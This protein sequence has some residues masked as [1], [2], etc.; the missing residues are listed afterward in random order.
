MEKDLQKFSL[1][2]DITAAI[3]VFLSAFFVTLGLGIWLEN[4]R[5]KK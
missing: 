4:L 5:S 2:T 1:V 3:I